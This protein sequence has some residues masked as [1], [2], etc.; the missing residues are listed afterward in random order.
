MVS[1]LGLRVGYITAPLLGPQIQPGP[2]SAS[3]SPAI[4]LCCF[5]LIEEAAALPKARPA[6]CGKFPTFLP[7]RK[8]N[9]EE[10]KPWRNDNDGPSTQQSQ[11]AALPAL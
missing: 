11:L 7:H 4:C 9:K 2:S 3:T 6:P 1:S 5:P 8:I 10:K